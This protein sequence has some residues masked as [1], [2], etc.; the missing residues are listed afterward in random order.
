MTRQTGSYD[1]YAHPTCPQRLT[2]RQ[3]MSSVRGNDMARDHG[4][5]MQAVFIHLASPHDR[6]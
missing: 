4:V 5:E 3:A 1:R 6:L 2:S